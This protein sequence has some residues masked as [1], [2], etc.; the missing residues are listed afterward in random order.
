MALRLGETVF[1]KG[2]GASLT[3]ALVGEDLEY[4][5]RDPEVIERILIHLD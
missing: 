5:Y 4:G 3:E 2:A 1:A